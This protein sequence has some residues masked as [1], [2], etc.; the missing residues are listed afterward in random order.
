MGR[1][2]VEVNFEAT[3]ASDH[4]D[5]SLQGPAEVILDRVE[6]LRAARAAVAP[7]E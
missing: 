1:F 5:V 4:L 6:Q 2:T 3:P 7:S